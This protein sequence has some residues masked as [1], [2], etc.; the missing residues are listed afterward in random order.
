MRAEE[1]VDDLREELDAIIAGQESDPPDD[2]HDVEGSS[3]AFERAR[4]KALLTLAESRLAAI[5]DLQGD[6]SAGSDRVCDTC[7]GPIGEERVAAL[8]EA[9]RCVRCAAAD[10][11]RLR[12]GGGVTRLRF[13]VF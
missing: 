3:I 12:L 8:P 7:G 9:R 4:V 2:E 11:P 1:L 5:D 10:A 13:P 6:V